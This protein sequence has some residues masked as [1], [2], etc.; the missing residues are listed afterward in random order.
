M[1]ALA[2]LDHK[3]ELYSR[4]FARGGMV[5]ANDPPVTRTFR[6]WLVGQVSGGGG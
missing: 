3:R 2:R 5:V 6:D 4:V 1:T